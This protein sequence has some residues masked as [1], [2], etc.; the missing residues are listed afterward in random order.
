M[1][2]IKGKKISRCKISVRKG[3][4]F[5]FCDDHDNER[6]LAAYRRI[7]WVMGGRVTIQGL[8]LELDAKLCTLYHEG[9]GENPNVPCGKQCN[10]DSF[11]CA[12]HTADLEAIWGHQFPMDL[13]IEAIKSAIRS[14]QDATFI[15][16]VQ[17]LVSVQETFD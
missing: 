1:F 2:V 8:K 4:A 17:H 11:V 12:R 10:N 14:N 3:K 7:V 13:I 6:V 15:N 5:P 9:E 16:I